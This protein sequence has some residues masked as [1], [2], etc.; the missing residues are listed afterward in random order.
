MKFGPKLWPQEYYL[1]FSMIWPSDLLIKTIWPKHI[2]YFSFVKRIILIKFD[3]DWR[4]IK[5]FGMLAI[6]FFYSFNYTTPPVSP[7]FL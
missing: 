2:F 1:N 5:G 6:F 4:K 3:K 7:S